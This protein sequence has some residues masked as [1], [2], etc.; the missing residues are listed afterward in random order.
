M[1]SISVGRISEFNPSEEDIVPYLLRLKHFFKANNVKKENEVSVLITVIG[2]RVLS[3]LSDL[4][5]P[6]E[7]DS[8]TYD[9]LAAL[10]KLHYAPKKLVVTERYVFYSRVQKPG[11]SIAEFV[12]SIKHLASS[13]KFGTF[14]KDALRDK[15]ISGISN[16]TIRQKL[17]S[18]ELD[19]DEA[20][21]SAL[22]LEQAE[23]Q[24]SLFVQPR[25]D[26]A[27]INVKSQNRPKTF[28]NRSSENQNSRN[29]CWRLG[30]AGHWP[31]A[32]AFAS[33]KC[34]GCQRVGHLK[35]VCKAKKSSSFHGKKSTP[36]MG[37]HQ[38][39][40]EVGLGLE[41]PMAEI[42]LYN[43]KSGS[44]NGYKVGLVA[45]DV[46]LEMILDT[47]S[48]LTIC[49]SEIFYE[50]ISNLKLRPAN[51]KL[52]TYSGHDV[53]VLG[54]V[55]V[56]VKYNNQQ[57]S[58]P[59]TVVSLESKSQ[60]ILLGRNWLGQLRL[61]WQNVFSCKATVDHSSDLDIAKLK[62]KFKSV[63]QPGTGEIKG[64]KA[65]IVLKEGT[66]PKFCKARPVPFALREKVESEL[67]RMV[68]EDVAYRV[69]NSQWSTPLVVV[70]KPN[71][72]RLCADYKIT[73]N[74]CI[75]MEHYPLPQAQDIFATLGGCSVFSCL[76]LSNAY[77]QLAVADESQHLLTLATHKGLYRL[78]RL[79]YGL[80]S[81]PAIF[82]SAID[83]ILTG[84]PGTVAYLDD[85]LVAARSKE[86]GLARLAQVLQRLDEFG[87][88]VNQQKC[89]FLQSSI[90]YLGH[91]IT[92]DGLR[93]QESLL[94]ALRKAPE[95]S[96]KEELRAYIGL[97]N[98]YHAFIPNLS[99]RISCF[100]D[101]LHKDHPWVW[102]EVCSKTFQESKSWVLD[103]SLLVHYDVKKPIVLTC[104]A[105]PRGVAAVL[106]HLIDG[107][108]RPIAFAS[109]TLSSS[110]RNY[111]QLHREALAL[112]FGVK[113]FHKY[114]YGRHCILQT[115]HQPLT[116]IFG[117]KKGVPSMAAARLQRWALILSAYDL[118]VRYRKG[119]DV[120]H[121]DALSRLPLA[122][123]EP[124]ELDANF[125]SHVDMCTEV[126]NNFCVVKDIAPITALHIGKMT[127]KDPI[128]SKVRD[129]VMYGWTSSDEPEL[130]IFLRK[131]DELSVEQGCLL[132]G[133]RVVIP[134]KLYSSVLQ[135]LHDQH[136]GVTRMKMLARS[137]VW[138]P[139]MEKSIEDVVASCSAC[140]LTR[141]S[142]PKVPLQ[143]WPTTSTRWQRTHIDFAED[144]ESRQQLL[145][146]IDTYSKWLEV[147]IMSSMNSSKVIEKLRTLFSSYGLPVE[148]VSDNGR[149]FTSQE[150]KTFL[151]NNNVKFTLTPPY[152]AASN[153]SAERSVQE[154]KKNLLRQ[155][156]EEHQRS[157]R[158][159][160]QM[161]L[162]NFLFAY[163]N[164]PNTVTGLTPAE[165]FLSWKPRTQLVMLKPNLQSSI[166]QKHRE[167][168]DAADRLR[169]RSRFFSE[170]QA[171][172]V[173]T[174]RNEKIS[175]VPGKII[176]KRSPV[177]YLVSVIGGK[178][179]FCHAD[180]LRARYAEEEE[181]FVSPKDPV[182]S[183]QVPKNSP[184]PEDRPTSPM[185]MSPVPRPT[186]SPRE[187]LGQAQPQP[188]PAS[189][190]AQCS[191]PPSLRKS[192]RTVRKPHR[193]D[194]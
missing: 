175:W 1:A 182:V 99:A 12:V 92:R 138:W 25:G 61:D 152:H 100:Y 18:E 151:H 8:K 144:P 37:V 134:K 108:E 130:A 59:L 19:F 3:V 27:K 64:V 58:L 39:E 14:L 190:L 104:D 24:S 50:K 124:I 156:I 107:Q 168:K 57:A 60:P 63:F 98:Y 188:T 2:P 149:S 123:A 89:K 117:S 102:S 29:S 181:I 189:P 76:D 85:V 153:G 187:S 164:T 132:W 52:T 53:P 36:R 177:T 140:Q 165:M 115:D 35:K 127:D 136:L 78:K 55:N 67:D 142:I 125:V 150:F 44:D 72:V 180:H 51:V 186:T 41:V 97:I 32:C 80:S 45:N 15:V 9:E 62:S 157:Q 30:S 21:A 185:M 147:F 84:L 173:K 73:L 93:P 121:A 96:T 161:K 106:S 83:Q 4:L 75:E 113:K 101:L 155:V 16:E 176:L 167:Q 43:L 145:V 184:P 79:P 111:S 20:Y 143:Q 131:K 48:A 91:V 40:E 38:V 11:E 46:Y 139:G 31:S 126:M 54:Q 166:D 118:E 66:V 68:Q 170:G 49:P 6:V 82:Q 191:P 77:Q 192:A 112:I 183:P 193:L 110:E 148:L 154:V 169:G 88:R 116:A 86:E 7:V 160:L 17:L 26:I 129:F 122:E 141:N 178:P 133:S 119:V 103:S 171:V 158:T 22:R 81:A 95:P 56:N 34:H 28:V 179:R 69:T 159:T 5:S 65:H 194:L 114:I 163:R 70:P 135:M 10:L 71:G 120:P 74:Q 42:S 137:Y 47:G 172:Y 87:V 23:S 33:Y 94:T 13:C 90:E 174:V 105:S 162:D 146:L 109:K 128:L